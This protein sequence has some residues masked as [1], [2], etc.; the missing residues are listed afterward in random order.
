[1]YIF[2]FHLTAFSLF[3]KFQLNL[4]G[5]RSQ[6]Y[7]ILATFMK[8]AAYREKKW[9]YVGYLLRKRLQC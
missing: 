7:K 8:K 3:T 9:G 5:K 2:V 1:M 6:I 4:M